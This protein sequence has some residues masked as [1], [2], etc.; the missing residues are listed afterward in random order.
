MLKNQDIKKNLQRK[1]VVRKKNNIINFRIL[2]QLIK[3]KLHLIFNKHKHKIKIIIN[4]S[5]KI[6][7]Y[8]R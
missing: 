5:N 7:I 1:L 6:T 4:K 3:I 8:L 2:L